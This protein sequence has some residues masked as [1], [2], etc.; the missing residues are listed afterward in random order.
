MLDNAEGADAGCLA[1]TASGTADASSRYDAAYFATSC[2]PIPYSREHL[3]WGAFFGTIAEHIV[4]LLRARRVFDAGCAH[5]FLVEALWDRGVEAWGRD[6]SDFAISQARADIRR[7]LSQ[8]SIAEPLGG[9]YDLVTCIEVLE[10]MP[11]EESIRAIAALGA[12]AP[13]ILFSSSPTDLDEP[14]HINVKP[15]RWWLDRFAEAGFAPIPEIDAGF[16]A[17]HAF[18]LERSEAGRSDRALTAFAALLRGRIAARSEAAKLDK[19]RTEVARLSSALAEASATAAA[20]GSELAQLKDTVDAEYA[21]VRAAAAAECARLGADAAAVRGRL[22]VVEAERQRLAP[23]AEKAQT[24]L[25]NQLLTSKQRDAAHR[26]ERDANLAAHQQ[27]KAAIFAALQA[28]EWRLHSA[29]QTRDAIVYST[30]WRATRPLRTLGTVL[31]APLRRVAKR[32]VRLLYWGVTFQA[33]PRLREWWK[34]RHAV[35]SAPAD[36]REAA[37]SQVIAIEAPEEG[38]PSQAMSIEAPGFATDTQHY[39]RWVR[40]CDTLS[41]VDR[42]MIREHIGR[43]AARPLVSVVMPVHNPPTEVLWEAIDSIRNQIYPYWELCIADDASTAEEVCK[44][45]EAA[46]SFDPRIRWIR[47][48]T[49]GHIAAA[50]NTALMLAEG[51]FVVLMDHDDRLADRA[52]YEVAALLNDHPDAEIIFSDED[53]F[54]EAGQ[55]YSPY[56]KPGWDPDLLLGQNCVSHLGAYRRALLEQI[57]GFRVGFEGSQDHDLAL[58]AA[59]ATSDA[60]IHHIPAVLYH[61]RSR[62]GASFSDTQLA[63]CVDASRRAVSEHLALLP[64]GQGAEVLPNPVVPFFHRIR[65]PLPQTPPKVSII[66][67]M[68]DRPELLTRCAA[69]I[70]KR[71]NYLNFELIVV[72]NGSTEPATLE[73]LRAL[74]HD[75]RVR[76]LRDDKPFNY[77][78]LNNRAVQV[79]TGEVLVLLNNDVDVRS[80]DWLR[81]MV[82]HVLRPGVGTVGARLL[83]E[84]GSVQHA[85]V[86]LGVGS[87]ANGPG[88]AG[89]FGCGEPATNSGYAGHSIL[90]RTVSGNTA[91]C[92]AVRQ[93]LY[94]E[95]GGL[96]EV[97][98]PVTFNDVDFCLRVRE[99]GLRNVWT[100][101]AELLHFESASR[102]SDLTE[103]QRLRF[104]N[105]CRYMRD[106]WGT[107]L[108][109]DPY[110]NANFSRFDHLHRLSIPSRRVSP[111]RRATE[112]AMA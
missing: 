18:I 57:G 44:V 109:N 31:P 53:R 13:R 97:H 28:S 85:G 14:T 83:Y 17:P 4:T 59:A 90:T 22:A 100:P 55:R 61:W 68:R 39:A 3:E 93:T 29:V 8:G 49:N 72:D 21:Q 98:L 75:P 11:E 35:P 84:D 15:I 112:G 87:W 99:R 70:L 50:S 111:W 40:E 69:G 101:A 27:E 56:F 88:L 65:W 16:L 63:R 108:D 46:A 23:L 67:P 38:A 47:R 106:R 62:S 58:R 24:A 42:A 37:P 43:F 81:E 107:V 80:S 73:A 54:D 95:I 94:L 64:G 7:F 1:T 12:A 45:I 6:I 71:T 36:M 103:E 91:A 41:D 33:T 30:C 105:E 2:S 51:E 32:G 79:A 86:V 9:P 25:A 76:V 34:A 78:A 104:E 52:L 110:Y 96:D 102:G 26:Q 82:S 60:R 77:A 66:V 5:G 10:H 48:E 92:L 20:A 19:L 89:H 74:A